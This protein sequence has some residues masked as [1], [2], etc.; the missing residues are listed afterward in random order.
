MHT[1]WRER[2]HVCVDSRSTCSEK[3]RQ[4]RAWRMRVWYG[5]TAVAWWP[6][7][8]WSGAWWVCLSHRGQTRT[9]TLRRGWWSQWGQAAKQ[10]PAWIGRRKASQPNTQRQWIGS[11]YSPRL[12][13]W[14]CILD[15]GVSCIV[16]C[17]GYAGTRAPAIQHCLCNVRVWSHD[18]GCCSIPNKD[19]RVRWQLCSMV[20]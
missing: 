3:E 1:F 18:S 17:H 13:S 9:R 4:A 6:C 12:T 5:W 10:H 16:C 20:Q 11:C 15:K 14:A 2:A 8:T 7:L 19:D